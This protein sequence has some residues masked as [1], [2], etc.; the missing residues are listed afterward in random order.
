[1]QAAQADWTSRKGSVDTALSLGDTWQCLCLMLPCRVTHTVL[2]PSS[3]PPHQV[4]QKLLRHSSAHQKIIHRNTERR[5]EW[6]RG[7][8]VDYLVLSWRKSADRVWLTL[9]KKLTCELPHCTQVVFLSEAVLFLVQEVFANDLIW[10]GR[11]SWTQTTVDTWPSLK[12]SVPWRDRRP[13]ES[14]QRTLEKS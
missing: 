4:A 13:S 8:S 10:K 6:G 12:P 14:K 2:T 5:L 3:S 9:I 7:W 1:M 11:V